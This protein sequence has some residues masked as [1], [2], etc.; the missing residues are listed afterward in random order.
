[1]ND[2]GVTSLFVY[3]TLMHASRHPM[4]VQLRSQSLYVGQAFLSA[5]L[6]DLGSYPGAVLSDKAGDRVHGD[7]VKLL[8]PVFTLA[9]LDDYEGCGA[10]ALEPQ[11]YERAIAPVAF[12]AGGRCNAW[13]YIYKMPVHHARRVP[14]GRFVRR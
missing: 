9:W 6:Y 14:H 1:M 8:W 7:V 5:R 11:S 3:G 2:M 10:G 12:I 4:A 13:V